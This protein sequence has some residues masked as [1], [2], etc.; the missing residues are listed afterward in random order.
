MDARE[1][2]REEAVELE[3][4]EA[5]A[6]AVAATESTSVMSV[7]SASLMIGTENTTY[8]RQRAVAEWQKTRRRKNDELRDTGHRHRYRGEREGRAR[9]RQ[10]ARV[11][12]T[13]YESEAVCRRRGYRRSYV[14]ESALVPCG[15]AGQADVTRD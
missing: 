5:A 11:R 6:A 12:A 7:S 15:E 2:G 8:E 13:D 14:R 10:R 1:C 3:D 9:Q 4:A